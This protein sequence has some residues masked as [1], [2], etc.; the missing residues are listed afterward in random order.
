MNLVKVCEKCGY[1]MEMH[2]ILYCPKC[3]ID[4]LE[5]KKKREFDF[6]KVMSHMEANGYMGKDEFWVYI[7][8][9]YNYPRNDSS[10]DI[11]I[12][13]DDNKKLS[14]M[15]EFEQYYYG[16]GHILGIKSGETVSM[17]CSW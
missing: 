16:L 3:N 2:Y 13:Y 12:E 6:L 11:I 5:M 17:W 1:K 4:I 7:C 9:K 14:K 8:N 10:F 15:D